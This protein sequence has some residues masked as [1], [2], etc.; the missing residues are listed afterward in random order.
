M[1]KNQAII[2]AVVT[3]TMSQ[4]EAARRFQVSRSWVS[5]LV[6]RYGAE[7]EAAFTPGSR[8]AHHHPNAIPAAT[9]EAILSTRRALVAAGHDAGPETITAHLARAGLTVSRASVWRTLA[10]A[11]LITPAPAKR[12]RSSWRS[13]TA[14]L[15]NQLWQ[16]DFTHWSLADR[17]G[18]EILTFLDDHSR[19]ITACTAHRVTTVVVVL[20][21]FRAAV[22][23]HG[24]PAGVLTDNGLVFTARPR[25]GINAFEAH[26]AAAGI[27][28]INGAPNHPQTQ[29]KVE[30]FQQSLKKHL[31][32]R[33]PAPDLPTLQA[34]IDAFIAYYNTVRPHRAL[35]RT[36]PDTAYRALPKATPTGA[37][38]GWR[39]RT[40]RVDKTGRVT[41]RLH[42]KLHHIG[43]GRT[44]ARTPIKMFL[45]GR[46]VL[47]ID[48]ATG[49][50]LR[51]FILDPA[52]DYQPRSL[53]QHPETEKHPGP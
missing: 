26:L 3:G 48:P 34:Q 33:A 10:R 25:H 11:G 1:E 12:P 4:A 24:A 44:Y 9:V 22:T 30:R 14:A 27:T 19:Y 5:K 8:A 20:T 43:I 7:G 50:I 52:R 32:T 40:D 36:T 15:P 53:D 46:H 21:D 35:D 39:I 13:F 17:T 2:L 16:A 28:K 37:P 29:G 31:A 23:A 41:V 45:H 49:V 42:S 18:V 47:I 51:N 38:T 6:A